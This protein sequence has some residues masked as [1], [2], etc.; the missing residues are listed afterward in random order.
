MTKW[1]IKKVGGG[2]YSKGVRRINEF[3]DSSQWTLNSFCEVYDI[4]HPTAALVERRLDRKFL[5]ECK[6]C[7]Q[8]M[9]YRLLGTLGNCPKCRK[10]RPPRAKTKYGTREYVDSRKSISWIKQPWPNQVK[11]LKFRGVSAA[12][13]G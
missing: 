5:R 4:P 2:D 12:W 6:H 11:Q 3:M 1:V 8:K 13:P 7:D 9:D 10:V